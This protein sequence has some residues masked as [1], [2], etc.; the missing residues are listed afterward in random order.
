MFIKGELLDWSRQ[1]CEKDKDS[2]WEGGAGD[3]SGNQGLSLRGCVCIHRVS[4]LLV[5]DGQ[6]GAR[7]AS[8][9]QSP[10]PTRG[11]CSTRG[12]N[13]ECEQC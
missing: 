11:G 12:V 7:C 6:R 4:G 5:T 3:A 10:H 8:C 2:V 9:A 1:V 13:T